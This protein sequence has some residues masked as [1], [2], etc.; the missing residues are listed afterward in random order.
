M[1]PLGNLEET[2]LLVGFTVWILTMMNYGYS[3]GISISIDMLKTEIDLVEILM[4]LYL[5]ASRLVI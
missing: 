3:L 2:L 1:A 5:S 4:T